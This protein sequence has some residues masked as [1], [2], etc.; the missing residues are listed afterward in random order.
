MR[1][2]VE[3]GSIHD[4]D[5]DALVVGIYEGETPN[6]GELKELDDRT[7]GMLAEVA[8]GPEMKGKSG[9]A[10]YLHRPRGVRARR[11]LLAGMGK[12]D[13]VSF[14]SVFK[15]C[16]GAARFLRNK[17]IKTFAMLRVGGDFDP[18]SAGEAAAEGL[19]A[20]LFEPD[21]YKTR[22][23]ADSGFSDIVIHSPDPSAGNVMSQGVE[24]GR[25]IGEAMN[26]A[27]ELSNEPASEL[28]PTELANRAAAAASRLGI[29]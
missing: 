12:R 17:G 19:I 1:I 3:G 8:G 5:V 6:H 15:Y 2:R 11:I 29:G 21:K 10:V 23:K 14:E 28:T 9:E 18:A 16:G 20:G 22:E 7:E 24:R 4:L 27:R 25:I 26:L 13:Q